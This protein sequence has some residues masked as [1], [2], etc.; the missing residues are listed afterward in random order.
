MFNT[1]LF[2]G[3][4]VEDIFKMSLS[5]VDKNIL[6]VFISENGEYLNKI[7]YRNQVY[8]GKFAGQI[9]DYDGLVLL[10]THIYSLLKKLVPDTKYH[11][12]KTRLIL[13]PLEDGNG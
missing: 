8:L 10:E 5:H 13:F 1:V 12:K 6:D 3:F 2:L 7:I 9:V 4:P 11:Y